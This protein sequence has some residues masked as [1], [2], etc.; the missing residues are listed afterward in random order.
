[1]LARAVADLVRG[2]ALLQLAPDVDALDQGAALVEARPARG[3]RG[4]EVQVTVDERR[5]HEPALDVDRLARLAAA[6]EPPAV[7]REVDQRAV[8]E[9][10]VP[11]QEVNHGASFRSTPTSVRIASSHPARSAW[12]SSRPTAKPSSWRATISRPRSRPS[13]RTASSS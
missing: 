6:H 7:D 4:V 12:S 9:P 1:D 3:Q 2:Q 8:L 5:R 13:R 11:Q 10:R